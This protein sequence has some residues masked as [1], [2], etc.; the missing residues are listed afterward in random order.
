MNLVSDTPIWTNKNPIIHKY[1]Y[2]SQ[3]EEC[4]ILVIG[5]GI[6]GAIVSYYLS[7]LGKKVILID[8]NII[9]YGSTSASTSILQY[10]VDYDIL[11]LEKKI[12]LVNALKAFKANENAVYEIE[13]IVNTLRDKCDFTRRDSLYFTQDASKINKFKEE[14]KLR[15][16]IDLDIEFIDKNSAKDKFSFNVE[17]GIYSKCGGGE[18]DPYKFTHELIKDSQQKRGL[19]VYENTPALKYQNK[20]N[21]VIIYT[22]KN[23][24]ITAQNVVVA[25]GYQA[26]KLIN[27][28]IVNLNTSYTITTKPVENFDGWYKRCIIR[29][30]C[31]PYNY[32]RTTKDNRI[33][34]GGE[35]VPMYN[36]P[37]AIAQYKY[38]RL[39]NKLKELFPNIQ[40]EVEYRFNGLFGDT[41]DGLPYIGKHP[42]FKNFYFALGYGSNGILYSIIAGQAIRDILAYGKTHPDMHLYS[43]NR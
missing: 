32:L 37:K 6:T 8:K 31:T 39:E 18:I 12:G 33:I 28:N 30:D 29:N 40:F 42:K 1:T 27:D 14:Y 7:F 36:P 10:E 35:D 21:K 4:D 34:I 26:S 9:G 16:A 2:L 3:D 23:K 24:K 20:N 17:A 11:E 22:N 25:T 43:F 13:W 5:A 19:I 38:T 41:K 15:R